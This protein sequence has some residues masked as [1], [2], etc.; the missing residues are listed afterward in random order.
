MR[1]NTNIDPDSQLSPMRNYISLKNLR[2]FD[3]PDYDISNTKEQRKYIQDIERLCRGSKAYK[4]L[5]QFLREHVDMNRCAFFKNINN[6]ETNSIKIEIHHT[7]LTLFDIVTTVYNKRVAYRENLS[8]N[9]VAKEVMWLHYNM[10]VGL[11]P[12]SETVHELV[13]SGNL[14]IPTDHVYGNY[15]QFVSMYSKFM[16]G[17]LIRTLQEAEEYSKAYD[18]AKETKVLTMHLVYIDPSGAYEFPDF[19]SIADLMHDHIQDFDNKVSSI[20]L[21]SEDKDKKVM[22]ISQIPTEYNITTPDTTI[23]YP[24]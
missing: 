14:F 3:I 5:I 15:R 17:G 12:L 20:Q 8:V 16:D 10:M 13:H 24:Q 1:D 18:F 22:E 4:D 11:I 23:G 6:I 19:K 2:D 21:G 7:P 9:M